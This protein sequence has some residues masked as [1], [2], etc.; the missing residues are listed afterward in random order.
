MIGRTPLKLF[1]ER[2]EPPC[3][4]QAGDYIR[5]ISITAAEYERI[6]ADLRSYK[7]EIQHLEKP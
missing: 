3:L 4:F 1:N 7:P 2:S 5:F 6:L